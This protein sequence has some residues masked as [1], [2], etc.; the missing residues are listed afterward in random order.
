ML[1]KTKFALIFAGGGHFFAS[2]GNVTKSLLIWLC[3]CPWCESSPPS[4]SVPN[5]DQKSS[6]K[7]H[8][9]SPPPPKKNCEKNPAFLVLE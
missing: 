1:K 8:V 7:V 9:S 3:L 6:P 5:E 2:V 4:D